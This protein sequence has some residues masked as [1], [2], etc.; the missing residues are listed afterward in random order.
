MSSAILAGVSP[1]KQH[2][3]I[4]KKTFENRDLREPVSIRVLLLLQR[5][6]SLSHYV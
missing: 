2:S 3:N 1:L 6:A 4:K 5:A